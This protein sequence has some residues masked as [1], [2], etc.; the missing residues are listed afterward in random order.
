[1]TKK[2]YFDE[3][4]K[5]RSFNNNLLEMSDY[6]SDNT[7]RIDSVFWLMEYF[8]RKLSEIIESNPKEWFEELKLSYPDSF[9]NKT[10]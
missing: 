6:V 2:E 4:V 9:K 5:L 1:M 3:L 8:G 7:F 10:A